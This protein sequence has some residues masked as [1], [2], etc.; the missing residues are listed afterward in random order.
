MTERLTG[1]RRY[2]K[3]WRGRLVLQVEKV[4]HYVDVEPMDMSTTAWDVVEW[5]DAKVE[6]L[7]EV[8]ANDTTARP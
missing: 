8:D 6:D 3:G 7:T 1:R 4:Q 2:R 5:R